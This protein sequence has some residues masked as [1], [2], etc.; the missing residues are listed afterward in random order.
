MIGVEEMEKTSENLLE[1]ILDRNNLNQ[2]Y[3]K[4]FKNRGSA[5]IDNMKVE[6]MLKYLKENK[7][8]LLETLKDGSYKPKPVK[9]V[10]IPKPNGGKRLLGIPTVI[11]RMIQQS[12]VQIISPIF[13]KTFSVYSYGFRPNKNAH[14]AIEKAK[15]Y[16]DEGYKYVVDIDL[17][18][19]FDTVNHDM[20]INM[21]REE[22]KDERVIKLIRKYLKS[23]V[24]I[25]GIIS[26]TTQGT[27]QGGNLS[28]LLSNIYLTKF[29]KMLE[30][31]GHKFVRYADDCNIY[32]KSKRASL[33][34]MQ[35]CVKFLEGKLK[36]KVNQEKSRTGSPL[37]LKFL[38]FSLYSM[39]GKSG[40]RPHKENIKRF[41]E[42]IKELTSR[43]QAKPIAKILENIKVYTT[44]WLGYYSICDMKT[45][46]QSLNEWIRR[47]IRQIYW[48]QWKRVSA[49]FENL[50]RLC[51]TKQKAWEWANS[52]L[53]YWRV[54]GSFILSTTLTN[55]YLVSQGYDDISLRYERLH[56]NY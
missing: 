32:V 34:V 2:A 52:R 56:L 55:E 43:K 22:I 41:K 45:R 26:A 28:P 37:R 54:A 48:K 27:P 51:K 30:S 33:R 4:V 24:M 46:I 13:E 16:Y 7:V 53:G 10:E 20:L 3:L 19:Y 50:K 12:I 6:D 38:G 9:R 8:K 11:D 17:A 14:Q 5:G 23:G 31:R 44:G 39:K 18:K 21:L 42:R 47:R 36:L 40:I 29:D 1:K 15:E 25:D 35:S 49:R